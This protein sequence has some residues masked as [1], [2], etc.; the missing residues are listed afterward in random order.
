MYS[1]LAS[2][3]E[4]QPVSTRWTSQHLHFKIYK[5]LPLALQ[6][7]RVGWVGVQGGSIT[8]SRQGLTCLKLLLGNVV[9]VCGDKSISTQSHFIMFPRV[10][11]SKKHKPFSD[12]QKAR[13]RLKF[14]EIFLDTKE[15]FH[16]DFRLIWNV[17]W[18][19]Q[20]DKLSNVSERCV[21]SRFGW[22][23]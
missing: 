16:I 12:C 5:D 4:L 22:Q 2:A 11:Y 18:F 17:Q 7:I 21:H 3:R 15:H 10:L 6:M 14:S 9:E 23:R 1:L 19:A 8:L 13:I 20:C